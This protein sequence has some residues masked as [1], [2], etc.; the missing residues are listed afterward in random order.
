MTACKHFFLFFAMCEKTIT[1]VSC[2]PDANTMP[3]N[4]DDIF[5]LQKIKEDDETAFKYLFETYFASVYRL[6]FFYLKEEMVAEEIALDVFTAF[7]EKRSVVRIQVSL[8]AYLLT[9]ARNRTMNYIRDNKP[10]LSLDHLLPVESAIE[11]Y[12]LEMKELEYLI[13]EAVSSLP[14]KC[15]EVFRK[16]RMENLTNK[17]IAGQMDISVKTVETQITKALKHIKAYLG[18]AYH[19]LW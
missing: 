9:S 19:Y 8:K 15:R 12:P 5:L 17:E 10:T 16:S 4:T 3:A 18:D 2:N 1:F 13:D 6:A 11:E 14:E 7:W